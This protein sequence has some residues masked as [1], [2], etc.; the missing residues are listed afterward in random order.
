MGQ[1]PSQIAGI[2]R[3]CAQRRLKLVFFVA[4]GIC[5]EQIDFQPVLQLLHLTAEHR[6]RHA[7]ALARRR[8]AAGARDG[9]K[10]AKLAN[11]R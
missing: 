7:Q 4:R 9:D 5:R 11:V 2:T 8:Q 6:L 10:I 3:A 1:Q